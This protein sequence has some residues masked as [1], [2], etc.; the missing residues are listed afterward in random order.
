MYVTLCA[1]K[2]KR[3]GRPCWRPERSGGSTTKF[4]RPLNCARGHGWK[5]LRGQGRNS[6]GAPP[7]T[8]VYEHPP[9]FVAHKWVDE[10]LWVGCDT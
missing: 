7:Q 2:G 1:G 8:Y 3:F 9:P 6:R 5:G 10:K 4:A